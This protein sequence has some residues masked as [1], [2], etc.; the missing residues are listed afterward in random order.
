MQRESNSHL[1]IIH[2]ALQFSQSPNTT[3]EINAFISSLILDPKELVQHIIRQD[4][5]IQDTDGVC[6]V[7]ALL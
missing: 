3:Y 6:G 2:P 7:S 4:A 1:T 5:Y